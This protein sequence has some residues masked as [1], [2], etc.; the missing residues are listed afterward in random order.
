[1]LNKPNINKYT[2]YQVLNG[3]EEMKN[4]YQMPPWMCGGGQR[5]TTRNA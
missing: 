4:I 2:V 1:M 3:E 5:A